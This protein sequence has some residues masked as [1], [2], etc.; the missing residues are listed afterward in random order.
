MLGWSLEKSCHPYLCQ[1]WQMKNT[2]LEQKQQIKQLHNE[3]KTASE[4]ATSLEMKLRT[5]RKWLSR[6]KKGGLY[7]H[8]WDDLPKGF[9]P[10]IQNRYEI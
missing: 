4:I 2:S 5:V 3:G 6:I 9:Y 10:L 1:K 8:K 7:I